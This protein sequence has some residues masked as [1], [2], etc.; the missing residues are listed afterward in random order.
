MQ[1]KIHTCLESLHTPE[2]ARTHAHTR[3]QKKIGKDRWRTKERIRGYV[4][5][6]IA[7]SIEVVAVVF[8]VVAVLAAGMG[9]R[10]IC[11]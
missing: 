3:E 8:H 1:I 5:K 9:Y 2:H 10:V 4:N 6:D 11:Y 7:V